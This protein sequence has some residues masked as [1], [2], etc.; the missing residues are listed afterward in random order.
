ML[1]DSTAGKRD[2]VAFGRELRLARE[3]AQLSPR[4]LAERMDCTREALRLWEAGQRVPSV[5]TVWRLE[6]AV[7]LPKGSLMRL[8]HPE[9]LTAP[10]Q[11]TPLERA[12]IADTSLTE[13][14]RRSLGAV[15][16][17]FREANAAVDGA[18]PR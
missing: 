9:M 1:P 10:Y 2:A 17:A 13:A 5:D 12:I 15:L 6:L 16:A 14:Q 11:V 8:V 18:L 4:E 3:Q 7:Q